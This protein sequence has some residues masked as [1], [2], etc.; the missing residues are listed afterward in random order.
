MWLDFGNENG[1]S[2]DNFVLIDGELAPFQPKTDFDSILSVNFKWLA[3]ENIT[4]SLPKTQTS[5]GLFIFHSASNLDLYY[6]N[7]KIIGQNAVNLPFDPFIFKLGKNSGRSFKL[8][9]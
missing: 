3:D 1:W 7:D 6:H 4:L 8:C 9:C 5:S 2:E